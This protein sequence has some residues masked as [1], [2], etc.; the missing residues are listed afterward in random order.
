MIL[1]PIR[2]EIPFRAEFHCSRTSQYVAEEINSSRERAKGREGRCFTESV[3]FLV[4]LLQGGGR[5]GPSGGCV[6]LIAACT[7]SI[8]KCAKE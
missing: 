3:A 6:M 8:E 7:P 1:A 2:L 4:W 5:H